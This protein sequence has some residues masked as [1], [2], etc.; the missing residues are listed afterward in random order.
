[1]NEVYRGHEIV[2]VAGS[3]KSAVI[4][5]SDSGAELPTKIIALPDEGE[6]AC[7]RRARQLVDL[8]LESLEE[9]AALRRVG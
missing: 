3:P 6:N 9:H 5:E 4:F 1:M 7:L 2:L 8:Y